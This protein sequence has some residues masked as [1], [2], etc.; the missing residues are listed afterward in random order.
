MTRVFQND[1]GLLT[2]REYFAAMAM[3]GMLANTTII[4]HK[5]GKDD[6]ATDNYYIA[7]VVNYSVK[8]SDVLINSLNT[9]INDSE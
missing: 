4:N 5:I 1:I 3:Q 2:K 6:L 7:G 8:F 9:P